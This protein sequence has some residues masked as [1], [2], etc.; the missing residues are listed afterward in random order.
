MEA[1]QIDR[2][3]DELETKGEQLRALYEQYFMGLE[4]HEPAVLRRDVERRIKLLRREQIRNTAQRFKFNVLVQRYNTMQQHWARVVRE[5]ENGTYRRDVLRAAARFGDGV[6]GALAKKKKAKELAG[7]AAKPEPS[8]APEEESYELDADDL[9]EDE[10]EEASV[11][12]PV[13]AKADPVKP[14]LVGG[15]SALAV[16]GLGAKKVEPTPPPA[17]SAPKADPTK[18][19]PEDVKRK[20]AELAAQF[21]ARRASPQQ[22]SQA[23]REGTLASQALREATLASPP[24]APSPPTPPAVSGFGVL[25]IPFG[26]E[27]APET[28]STGADATGPRAPVRAVPAPKPAAPIRADAELGDQR[29]RQIYA[30]YVE[31]KRATQESTAGVTFEKLAASLR[32]QADKLKSTHPD[33]SIDYEV[34]VKDGKTHLKPVLR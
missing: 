24:N 20:V 4:R 5:I 29:I 27:P 16:S 2:E 14:R 1:A 6:L 22:A 12:P 13:A 32:A 9:I 23:L 19:A 11:A 28:P 8:P 17:R 10:T 33:K 34:V 25:D 21:S 30:K 3:L 7:A 15:L 31:T 18:S 26:P